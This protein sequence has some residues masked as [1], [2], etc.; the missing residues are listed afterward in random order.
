MGLQAEHFE[1]EQQLSTVYLA[2]LCF[3]PARWR[4]NELGLV[5]WVQGRGEFKQRWGFER[6]VVGANDKHNE[7]RKIAGQGGSDGRIV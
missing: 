2:T 1:A 4:L 5:R 7:G 6:V 3:A